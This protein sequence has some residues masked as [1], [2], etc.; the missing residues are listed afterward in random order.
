MTIQ[1]LSVEA[2]TGVD[3]YCEHTLR[4]MS[5]VISDFEQR[6]KGH[7]TVEMASVWHLNTHARY[8]QL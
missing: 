4:C 7:N 8:V 6:T 5:D 3:V 1:L 2:M